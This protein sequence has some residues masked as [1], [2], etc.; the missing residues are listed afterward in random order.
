MKQDYIDT[1]RVLIDIAPSIFKSPR[2]AMKGGTA[3]NLFLQD[4]PR[5]SVDI[6]VVFTDHTLSRDHA[7][8]AIESD[9]AEAAKTLEGRGYKI[10]RPRKPNG[11]DVKLFVQGDLAEVKV[12]VNH[13]FRGVLMPTSSTPLVPS[14]QDMFTSGLSVPLLDYREIYGSKL[15]AAMDGQHPRDIFDVMK[16]YETY[17]LD[18]GF[19]DCFVACLAGHGRPVH[20]VLFS[21]DVPLGNVFEQHFKGM[22]TDD[23]ALATLEET[24]ARLKIELPRALTADHKA[25][26]L[27]L[28][29]LEPAWEKMPFKSLAD[30]P[31]IRWKIA[32]LEK[33]RTAKPDYFSAQATML[34]ERLNA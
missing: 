13:I 12:E 27:S 11:E 24:R 2:F 28:V 31:A 16:M 9:L 32:N 5:L 10:I 6:D 18:P 23:V 15:V 14:A 17:G 20:E 7:L 34:E 25:F 33:L 21:N 29:R 3:L 4:M 22:T 8:K 30:L 1:V 26:L 19:V